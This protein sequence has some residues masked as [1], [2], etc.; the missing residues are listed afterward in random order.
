MVISSEWGSRMGQLKGPE[1]QGVLNRPKLLP[2]SL[3]EASKQLAL[4]FEGLGLP[5]ASFVVPW[6]GLLKIKKQTKL[7]LLTLASA[8]N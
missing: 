4:E 2:K 1:I 7:R 5:E 3:A 6:W 8:Y